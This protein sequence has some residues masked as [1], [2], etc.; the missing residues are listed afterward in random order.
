LFI[1][2]L[3]ATTAAQNPVSLTMTVTPTSVPAG[4]K[5]SA[6]VSASI[7]GGWHMYSLTQGA[8]GPIPTRI[9]I[10]EGVFKMTGASGPKPHVAMVPNFPINTETYT[11]GATFNVGFSVA[12]TTPEGQQTLSVNVRY[13]VCNDTSCLP[14]KTAKLDA[15]V[16]IL[17]AKATASP[18][19]GALP[20]PTVASA[21]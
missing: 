10:P 15:L 3:V 7:G 13:Q 8:G 21:N 2:L 12:P 17:P 5:G 14:P 1:C 11:G 19:P 9:S 4:G 18:T 20:S 6:K 16:T